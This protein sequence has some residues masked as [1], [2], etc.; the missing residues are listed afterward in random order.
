MTVYENK[1]AQLPRRQHPTR[2][3]SYS[4][5][6]HPITDS[7]GVEN[8]RRRVLQISLL[9]CIIFIEK[10]KA[11]QTELRDTILSEK[12]RQA[13]LRN[14]PRTA[15]EPLTAAP[16]TSSPESEAMELIA[17]QLSPIY[18]CE[19][20][21][22]ILEEASKAD[23]TD[24]ILREQRERNQVSDATPSPPPTSSARR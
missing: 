15:A 1:K 18:Q 13:N 4:G 10:T 24:T 11:R 8:A 9:R 2:P 23:G 5:S 16:P 3:S 20:R 14:P 7:E 17:L 21:L 22:R 12:A 19:Q 6:P